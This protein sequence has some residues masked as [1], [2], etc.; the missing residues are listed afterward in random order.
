MAYIGS[1]PLERGTGLFSQDSFTGDGSTTTFDMTN[2]A[3]DGGGNELQV[4][5]ANVRQQE[6]VSNA[7][8]LGFDGSGDLKR[9]TFTSAPAT[10]DVIQVRSFHS[11]NAQPAQKFQQFTTTQRDALSSA[12]GDVIYN[13]TTNKFQG[14]A[15]GS[16]VDFH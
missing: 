15:N 5:V 16:W 13:T 10:G 2:I 4:F 1:P 12:N 11:G 9:I 6:G 3:P 14:Y 8:T 7:Y